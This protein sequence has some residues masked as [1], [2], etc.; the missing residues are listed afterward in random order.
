M[1]ARVARLQ[2]HHVI[3][4][5]VMRGGPIMLV[6][7]EPVTMLRMIVIGVRV[8]VQRRDL[9]GR[10]GQA[11][12]EQNGDAAVHT[13]SVCNG[14]GMVKSPRILARESAD[15]TGSAGTT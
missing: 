2:M 5:V 12:S 8:D 14:G 10:R 13:A 3:V 15:T 1:L 4:L 7:S 6:R 11:Q 9:A